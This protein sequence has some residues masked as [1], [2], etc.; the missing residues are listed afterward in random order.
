MAD[1][2][3]EQAALALEL[4]EARADQQRLG[5]LE[6]RDRIARDL[7]DHVIQRLF[8]SALA[9]GVVE[10]SPDAMVREDLS[11]IVA[12]LTGTIRQIRGTIF[13]SPGLASLA[14]SLRRVVGLHRAQISP[15][16]GVPAG[17]PPRRPT[18]HPGG[19]R[20]V[21]DVEAVV[22]EALTNIGRHAEATAAAVH[23]DV[24]STR[25]ARGGRRQRH[26]HQRPRTL[27]SGLANL[28]ARAEGRGGSLTVDKQAEG[29]F[30]LRWTI[31]IAL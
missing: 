28:R 22:R 4:A 7:H 31:P 11:Q 27:R 13:A 29:G 6:D 18:G 2:F 21:S 12:E 9:P 24:D 17:C 30:R 23:L 10:R 15:G 5:V 26:R 20:M 19:R 1:A 14:T 8:A 16:A 3:A 25:L